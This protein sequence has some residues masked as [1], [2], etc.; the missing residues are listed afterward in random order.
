[1]V[2][3]IPKNNSKQFIY[4]LVWFALVLP[5]RGLS[6]PFWVLNPSFPN[7]WNNNKELISNTIFRQLRN[8]IK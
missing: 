3:D 6:N 2:N 5:L 1:M 4:S 7:N 8:I